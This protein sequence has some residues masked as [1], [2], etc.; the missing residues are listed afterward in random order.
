MKHMTVALLPLFA[1]VLIMAA[2]KATITPVPAWSVS[3]GLK[4]P[5]SV[6][7][8]RAGGLL[9]VSNINGAPTDQDDNGFITKLNPDGSVAQLAWISGESEEVTLHAPKGMAILGDTLYVAD[10][11]C[12]RM[13][14]NSTG[15]PAG[16]VCIDGATFLNDVTAGPGGQI[17]VTDSGLNP[18]FS[19]AGTDAASARPESPIL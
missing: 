9:Y 2:C 1:A 5:E 3:D 6:L 18:D 14:V 13:F 17:Y 12:V 15:A 16:E 8:D 11:D 19:P 10:I 7:Y 4:V